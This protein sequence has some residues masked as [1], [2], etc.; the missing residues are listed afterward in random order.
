MVEMEHAK[1]VAEVIGEIPFNVWE[2]IVKEEPEWRNME[3][4]LSSYDFGRF[5]VLMMATGLNDFQLRG[6]AEIA[7][8]PRIRELLEFS[9]VPESLEEMCEI[10][11]TFYRTERLSELKLR[12]LRRFIFSPVA[13]LIWGGNPEEVSEKFPEI[14]L[15]LAGTM[16]QGPEAKTI[17]F[18][19]KCLGIA[20]LIAGV[21]SFEF[22]KIPIPVDSRVRAF[23]ERLGFSGDDSSV[24]EFWN[25]VLEEMRKKNP[26]VTM[27]HLDS[28]IWQIGRLSHE[29]IVEYFERFGVEGTG[30][31]I[32]S[33]TR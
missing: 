7:Y 12:R 18:A 9:S 20:L 26:G 2:S 11:S 8:W 3:P 14:W 33:L 19:M 17:S 5:A 32:A 16:N 21:S 15:K 10:L 28:L 23:T 29:E 24:R 27:I 30:K 4:F 6:K 13:R 25:C 1:K 22:E 31:R